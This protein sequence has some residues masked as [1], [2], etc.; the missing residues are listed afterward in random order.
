MKIAWGT[1][2]MVSLIGMLLIC[3]NG[4]LQYGTGTYS[5][6]PDSVVELEQTWGAPSRIVT[7][8]QL[9]FSE[10]HFEDVEIWVY[11]EAD[12]YV[13]V[14]SSSVVAVKEGRFERS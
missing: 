12:R 10:G 11:D 1:I 5:E 6:N 2:Q 9:G 4:G 14:R 3:F 13:I 7:A 8:D